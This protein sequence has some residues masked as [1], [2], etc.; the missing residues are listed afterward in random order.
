MCSLNHLSDVFL[1]KRQNYFISFCKINFKRTERQTIEKINKKE[2]QP[3]LTAQQM[4]T[5]DQYKHHKPK[6]NSANF[7]LSPADFAFKCMQHLFLPCFS[8]GILK[9][10]TLHCQFSPSPR[11]ITLV[12]LFLPHAVFQHKYTFCFKVKQTQGCQKKPAGT[13]GSARALPCCLWIQTRRISG[14]N[15]LKQ[16][17]TSFPHATR[18]AW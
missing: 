6:H 15:S 1:L 18:S 13:R 3:G 4:V 7:L 8:S 2:A 17:L 10:L 9:S 12:S 16:L 5:Q 14:S 11:G